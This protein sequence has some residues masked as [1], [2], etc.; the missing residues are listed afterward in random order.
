MLYYTSPYENEKEAGT[1]VEN[2]SSSFILDC[3]FWIYDRSFPMQ[4]LF[5]TKA[6]AAGA[7]FFAPKAKRQVQTSLSTGKP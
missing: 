2:Y 5:A 4:I 3:T 6:K 1:E 7:I